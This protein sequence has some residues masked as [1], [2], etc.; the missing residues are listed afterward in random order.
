ML[1]VY[2]LWKCWTGNIL[3]EQEGLSSAADGT[4]IENCRT[5][6]TFITTRCPIRINGERIFSAKG[7]PQLGEH[8][9]QIKA[10]FL[11]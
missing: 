3:T 2:G 7:A 6:K 11:N 5:E 8:T 1:P 9:E 4:N 10:E